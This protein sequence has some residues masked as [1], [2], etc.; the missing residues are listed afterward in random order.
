MKNLIEMTKNP[1]QTNPF[2]KKCNIL[3]VYCNYKHPLYAL[4]YILF[5]YCL[6][7]MLIFVFH[8][9]FDNFE[10]SQGFSEYILFFK[11]LYFVYS[12][13]LLVI[14]LFLFYLSKVLV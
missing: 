2:M 13:Y 7:S 4:F 14:S 12:S 6:S 3:F 1:L 11:E 9:F 8:I 5:I 10:L